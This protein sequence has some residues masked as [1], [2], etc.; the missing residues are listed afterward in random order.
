MTRDAFL[1]VIGHFYHLTSI[2]K[3]IQSVRG[4]AG[5]ELG[6]DTIPDETTIRHL[7]ERHELTK[8]IFS[9]KNAEGKRDP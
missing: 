6:Q 1:D 3:D 9:A 7:L 5:L 2:G 8:A 4:F